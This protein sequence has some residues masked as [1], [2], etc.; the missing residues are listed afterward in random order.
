MKVSE[1]A[2][3]LNLKVL[4]NNSGMEKEVK[5]GYSCDLLSWVMS[6][7]SKSNAWITVQVHPNIVAVALLAEFS[8]IIIPENIEVDRVTLDKANQEN[9]AILQGEESAFEICGKL[10]ELGI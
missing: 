4:T 6:H 8:C 9:I 2:E 10:K 7:G 5:G 1:V 3:K